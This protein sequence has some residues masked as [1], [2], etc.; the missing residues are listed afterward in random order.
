MK[1]LAIAVAGAVL[2]LTACGSKGPGND[3]LA[4]QVLQKLGAGSTTLVCWSQNG[5]LGG[6]FHHRYNRACG[7]QQ[8]STSIYIDLDTKKGTWCVITPR[9]ARLPLCPGFG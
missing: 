3:E 6:A 5:Y 1:L 2:L 8:G 7:A 4:A 9:Y